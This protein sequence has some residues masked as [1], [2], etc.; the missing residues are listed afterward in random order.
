MVRASLTKRSEDVGSQVCFAHTP[1]GHRR[2]TEDAAPR[3][4]S[5]ALTAGDG[6]KDRNLGPV[7]HGC[8]EAVQEA[9]VFA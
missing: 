5:A 4:V 9:D 8:R 7:G 3:R 1:P 2:V 6:G